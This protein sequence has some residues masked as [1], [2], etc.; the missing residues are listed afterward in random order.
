MGKARKAPNLVQTIRIVR[1]LGG[2]VTEVL[3]G[4]RHV[5]VRVV[6]QQGSHLTLTLSKGKTEPHKLKGWTRQEF[7]RADAAQERND[8]NGQ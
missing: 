8:N 1:E 5:R 6:T 2:Q 4:N 7:N 3:D